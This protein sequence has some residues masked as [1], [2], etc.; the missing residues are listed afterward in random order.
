MLSTPVLALL[1]LIPQG[2]QPKT[3]SVEYASGRTSRIQVIEL[4][5]EKVH[6]KVVVMGGSMELTRKL[7]DFKPASAFAIEVE[8]AGPNSFDDHF[9][10]AKKAGRLRLLVPA[11][12]QARAAVRCAG[13][14]K[15]KVTFVRAWAAGALEEMLKESVA[16]GDLND[17]NHYLKLLTTRLADQRSEEQLDS[18]A[19]LVGGLKL[20]VREKRLAGRQAKLDAKAKEAI[21]RRLKPIYANIEKGDKTQRQ[22]LAKSRNT[23]QSARLSESAIKSY[24]AAWK[25]AES[26][27]KKNKGDA[28][29]GAELES[30]ADRLHSNAIDA[31]LH[32]A[33]MLTVQSDYKGALEWT[34]KILAFDPGNAEAKAMVRTIQIASAAASSQWGWGWG[35]SAQPRRP[36]QQR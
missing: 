16:A 18:Y 36:Q 23:S 21:Q 5:G 8:G 11:G 26:L 9:R 25:A 14:D 27:G 1:T 12:S 31:A 34:S 7:S 6:F 19:S 35:R 33:N 15:A 4:K 32:A 17:A 22:A 28:E 13:S 30:I 29:L 20:K 2:Q 3:I 10:L 24:K